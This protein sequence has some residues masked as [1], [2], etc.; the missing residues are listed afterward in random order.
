MCRTLYSLLIIVPIAAQG[1]VPASHAAEE[2][3]TGFSPGDT[4]TIRSPTA[5]MDEVEDIFHF[6]GG[7]ELRARDWY[8]SSD[9]AIL[10][11]KL[12]DPETVVIVGSPAQILVSTIYHGKTT[13]INGRAERIIYQR[14][15]NSIRMEGNAFISRDEHSMSG[16]EIEYDI[17]NDHLRA[18]GDGGVHIEVIPGQKNPAPGVDGP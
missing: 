18:G 3:I 5:R 15:T 13:T 1:V 2:R 9:R 14:N 7:F 10:Y 6:E 12:D 8:L 17:E 11:G 4:L 16:G